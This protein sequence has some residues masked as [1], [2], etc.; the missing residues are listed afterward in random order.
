MSRFLAPT[1]ADLESLG[2]GDGPARPELLREGARSRTLLLLRALKDL[3]DDDRTAAGLALLADV[4]R[5]SPAAFAAAL[6][7]PAT[8]AWAAYCVRAATAA[9]PGAPL[10]PE[11]ADLAALAGAAAHRAGMRYRITVPARD[12][13]VVLP[14]LGLAVLPPGTALAELR[15][16]GGASVLCGGGR[17]VRIPRAAEAEAPGW[18]PEPRIRVTAAGRTLDVRLDSLHPFRQGG[19]PLPPRPLDAERRRAWRDSTAAAWAL[20]AERH[21]ARARDVA[22][23]VASVVPLTGPSSWTSAS[24]GD[25]VGAVGLSPH[26][27]ARSLAAALVHEAQHSK[28]SALLTVADL[29]DAPPGLRAYA[30]WRDDPRPPAGLLQG[31]Y[32]FLAVTGFWRDEALRAGTDEEVHTAQ[33]HFARWLRPTADTVAVLARSPW[34][35]AEGRLLL[36]AMR[37]TLADWAT[38]RIAP[39]AAA[40]ARSAAAAHRVRWRLRHAPAPPRAV[41]EALA[42]AYG[43]GLPVPREAAR[44]LHRSPALTPD[45]E[46]DPGTAMP[47]LVHAVRQAAGPAPAPGLP[48]WL[49]PVVERC[50]ALRAEP[51][52]HDGGGSMS[53]SARMPSAAARASG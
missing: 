38:T 46:P 14:G 49:R 26:P 6:D 23:T 2:R 11:A 9:G 39:D 50:A 28:L 20:L 34:P 40:A 7:L 41:V 44:L 32:A 8:G 29:L 30:P 33:T 37:R 10:P 53:H 42:A 31:A 27:D 15:G 51:K 3:G 1:R 25:A 12:G 24:Y 16:E 19:A 47:E 5:H 36:D 13:A 43:A 4:Q 45:A 22:A 35:T 52:N 18:H 48:G 17:T 21:P